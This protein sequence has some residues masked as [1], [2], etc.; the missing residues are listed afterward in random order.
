MKLPPLPVAPPAGVQAAG[1]RL[2]AWTWLG[3]A[4][5]LVLAGA[6]AHDMDHVRAMTTYGNF[7]VPSD[8]AG[9]EALAPGVPDLARLRRY[10][11]GAD[12]PVHAT[13]LIAL[14]TVFV[15]FLLLRTAGRGLETKLKI[16]RGFVQWTSF[17][18]ARIGVLRAANAVPVARCTFGVFPFLNCQYC[19]MASGA[20][21]VGIVQTSLQH[22]RV[23]FLAAGV[24]TAVGAASGRWICGWFCPFGL[25]LDICDRGCRKRTVHL[26]RL[27]RYGKFLM[28]G[29]VVAGAAGL[30]VGGVD[31]VSW[32]CSTICPA[33]SLYGLVPYYG[34]TAVAP[35]GAVFTHFDAGNAGHWLV[36]GHL[37]FF[38]LFLWVTF[39]VAARF[40]CSA[41]CPLGAALALFSR[42]SL[43]RIVH[44][45]SLC[46]GCGA[47]VKVC[48]MGID[49]GDDDWLTT[50]DCVQCTRCVRVCPTGARAWSF[51]D[52]AAPARTESPAHASV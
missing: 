5:L 2:P 4:L 28:L 48:P 47:C 10:R 7:D 17:V 21:P 6:L 30:A 33:G 19:E 50:T 46:D 9:I 11:F 38:A 45:A 14:G 3:V 35:F 42:T 41:M 16:R 27:L 25:F 13:P 15:V 44:K 52:E 32:F 1:S 37:L 18:L 26:P 51:R 22:G 36:V 39:R 8:R 20:C 12:V 40:F 34:T 49:L 23:P 31:G 43:V 24:V 29:L